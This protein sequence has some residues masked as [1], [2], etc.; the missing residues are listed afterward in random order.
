[1]TKEALQEILDL[2]APEKLEI[3]GK[4]WDSIDDSEDVALTQEEI[5]ELERRVEAHQRNP[6][7]AI[8]LDEVLKGLRPK[9]R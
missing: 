2:S 7:E 8:P 3:I 5:A 6:K 1:M 9:Q 4:I